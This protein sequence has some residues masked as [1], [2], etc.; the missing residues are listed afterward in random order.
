MSTT[1]IVVKYIIELGPVIL[2]PAILLIISLLTTRTPLKNLK[3]CT[4]IFIGMVGISVL[5]TLFVNFFKT[6]TN[7]ILLNS[8]KKFEIIDTGWLVS[9]AVILNSPVILQIII[10]VIILNLVMLSLRF[11]RTIN[12]DFWNYWSFLLVGAIVFSI[13]EIKWM[14]VLVAVIVAE[15]TFFL[16]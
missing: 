11:T 12:I 16:Y 2:I 3:N 10:A 13:T 1:Y 9:K 14:G 7:N 8:P 4:F 15:I 5:L 6:I